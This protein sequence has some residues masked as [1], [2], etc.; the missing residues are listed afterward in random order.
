[1][2]V[3]ERELRKLEIGKCVLEISVRFRDWNV[4][5]VAAVINLVSQNDIAL[6]SHSSVD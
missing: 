5:P 2:Q 1:M 4:Y 6:L 3:E